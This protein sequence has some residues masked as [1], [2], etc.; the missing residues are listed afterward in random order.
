MLR[1]QSKINVMHKNGKDKKCGEAWDL[2]KC[3]AAVKLGCCN[4]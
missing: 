1:H 2:D 3:S 4:S